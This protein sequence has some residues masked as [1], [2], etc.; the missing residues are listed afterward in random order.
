MSSRL[1]LEGVS[2]RYAGAGEPSLRTVGLVL[3]PGRVVGVAG[4]NESGKS[5]LCLV[6]GGLAPRAIG[7]RLEGSVRIDGAETAAM[8][9][10]DLAQRCGVLFQNAAAQISGTAAT[11]FEEVAFGPC[12]LGLPMADVL[13]RVRWAL[14]AVGIDELA[15]RDPARLSGGQAQLVA[16]ASVLALRPR[17][18]ILDEP[19]SELD[20]P[21]RHWWR[22]RWRGWR[23]TP[24]QGSCSWSTRR[25]CWPASPTRSS[26]WRPGRWHSPVPPTTCLPIHG[27][28]NWAS[29]HRPGCASSVKFGRPG[30]NGR[31]SLAGAIG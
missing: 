22:M 12:N 9:A 24:A 5:T 14:G 30:S 2:Y 15:P 18:L 25:M 26:F 17:Y 28:P 29:S 31:P 8:P 11:V 20:P 6:A 3:L 19:T 27:C 10:Y 23:A 13:E 4:P 21:E 16:L 7:G 1:V